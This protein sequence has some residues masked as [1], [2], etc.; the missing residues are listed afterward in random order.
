MW[1]FFRCRWVL[2]R[3]IWGLSICHR[4]STKNSRS[5]F[6]LS[7]KAWRVHI[8]AWQ[9]GCRLLYQMRPRYLLIFWW[10]GNHPFLFVSKWHLWGRNL[11]P[12]GKSLKLWVCLVWCPDWCG[13]YFI[14]SFVVA[15]W[16]WW[17]ISL[18]LIQ[19]LWRASYLF[20]RNRW[21]IMFQ[22]DESDDI[23]CFKVM[24]PEMNEMC[25]P[26]LL[27]ETRAKEWRVIISKKKDARWVALHT[28][29]VLKSFRYGLGTSA[30][31]RN[32]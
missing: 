26:C 10:Q 12:Q 31:R 4:E 1:A 22:G 9:K 5:W 8:G 20:L 28:S 14:F 7:R 16:V 2:Y 23:L 27:F 19:L 17:L 30:S 15:M 29:H 25:H 32:F 13:F 21:H 3:R 18:W 11:G 6:E 24:R